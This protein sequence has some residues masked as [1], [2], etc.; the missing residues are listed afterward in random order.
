MGFNKLDRQGK[1]WFRFHTATYVLLQN[2][3][4]ALSWKGGF[5]DDETT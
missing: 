1:T 5:Q 4:T 3:K 2:E